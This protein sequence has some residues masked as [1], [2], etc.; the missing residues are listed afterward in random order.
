[1]CLYANYSGIVK[2]SCWPPVLE[3]RALHLHALSFQ[4]MDTIAVCGKGEGTTA[5]QHVRETEPRLS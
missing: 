5:Y 4:N 3:V 1:M 2:A